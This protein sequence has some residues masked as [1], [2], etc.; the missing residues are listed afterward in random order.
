MTTPC[1]LTLDACRA[2]LAAHF[3]PWIQA[4][5]IQ[6]DAVAWGQVT[7][8]IAPSP[9]LNREGGTLC[10]QAMMALADT[11]M[12]FAV[13]SLS[14]GFV[15]MTTVSQNT[16]FL[17][18]AGAEDLICATRVIKRGRALVYGEAV[19]HTGAADKPI[20]HV[21]STYMLL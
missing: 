16:A 5:E 4:L 21:T 20:A 10:G 11:S 18:P 2:M 12:A 8:R 3:A 17:R 7:T 14:G 13:A 1:A 15:P 19:L 9:R 6:F